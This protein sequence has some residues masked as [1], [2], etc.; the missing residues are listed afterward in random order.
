MKLR[1]VDDVKAVLE[2]AAK[3]DRALPPVKAQ[4]VKAVWPDIRLTE[5]EKKALRQMTREGGPLFSP[6]QEQ[7]DIW[8]K[9]CTD[10]AHIFS[11]DD[12]RRQQWTIIWLKACRCRVK[13]IERHV[14]F[15]RTKI[16]YQYERGMAHLLNFLQ[17]S[18]TRED[19]HNL[20]VYKPELIQGYPVG[21]ITGL[22]KVNLLKEWLRELE[23]HLE[24]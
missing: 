13:T 19:L 6:T 24:K 21:K 15:G 14:H 16:W 10:W 2:L 1:T 7:V 18:Y 5:S 20:E 4:G 9:V 3:V 23:S 11:G 22:T 12:I 17:V 8:Y